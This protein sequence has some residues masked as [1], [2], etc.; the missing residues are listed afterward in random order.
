MNHILAVCDSEITY[1]YQLADYFTNKKG[2]PFQV[3]LF[4]SANTLEEYAKKKPL[5]VALISE[6]DYEEYLEQLPIE[7]LVILEEGRKSLGENIKKIY[8]YFT[9]VNSYT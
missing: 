6:K 8:K 4:T 5:S 3:Q 9:S 1:A 7:H 2:F